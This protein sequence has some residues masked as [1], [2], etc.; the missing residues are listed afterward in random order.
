MVVFVYPSFL[1][2]LKSNISVLCVVHSFLMCVT[3]DCNQKLSYQ[4]DQPCVFKDPMTS[5]SSSCET[6]TK[7]T[8]SRLCWSSFLTMLFSKKTH[9]PSSWLWVCVYV[10]VCYVLRETEG[11]RERERER[12]CVCG[13]LLAEWHVNDSIAGTVLDLALISLIF[14]WH[15]PLLYM[16]LDVKHYILVVWIV[17]I[18]IH[19]NTI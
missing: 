14:L 4:R 16:Q 11:E 13:D 19:V 3:S 5:V 9:W 1:A 18:F 8:C 12:V 15:L 6:R 2:W 10:N 17:T 7:T